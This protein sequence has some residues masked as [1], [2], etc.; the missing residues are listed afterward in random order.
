MQLSA[1]KEPRSRTPGDQMMTIE[2][3]QLAPSPS[4][5]R[6]GCTVRYSSEGP[7]RF[8]E[9][10]IPWRLFTPYDRAAVLRIFDTMVFGDLDSDS[11]SEQLFLEL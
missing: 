8:V 4:G 5:L 6:C 2:I 10:V 11:R 1:P 9:A 7:V 3:N